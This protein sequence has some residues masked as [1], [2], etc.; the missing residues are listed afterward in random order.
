[1]APAMASTGT[2]PLV[3]GIAVAAVL[4]AGAV[5]A[6]AQAGCDEPGSYRQQ[7]GVVEL[8]GGCVQAEDLPVSPEAQDGIPPHNTTGTS[9]A[10]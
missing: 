6:V 7:D 8:I 4:S 10:P 9:V 1:M 2:L 5:F 3:G